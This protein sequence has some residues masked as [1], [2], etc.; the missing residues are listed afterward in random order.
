VTGVGL[1]AAAEPYLVIA[2]TDDAPALTLPSVTA[3]FDSFDDVS[4]AFQDDRKKVAALEKRL[5]ELEKQAT[6]RVESIPVPAPKPAGKDAGAKDAKKDEKKPEEPY[7]VGSDPGMTAKWNYGLQVESAH[8]D[9]RVNVGGRIQ[10]DQVAFT[11]GPG[12]AQPQ[13]QGGLAPLLQNAMD[14]RR[15]RLRVSS[16]STFSELSAGGSVNNDS[17]T[18]GARPPPRR[19]REGHGR[20]RG[21][22]IPVPLRSP[23][24]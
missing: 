21:Q 11:E 12:P 9:F 15:A 19:A 7:E 20:R 10:M 13:D 22:Q 18:R 4:A 6:E 2:E 1:L 8:K 16:G 23:W 5:A 17:N 24:R 3:G 14:F